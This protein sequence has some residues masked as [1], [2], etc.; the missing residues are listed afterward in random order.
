[1]I[2]E[3]CVGN[4]NE[5][6]MAEK[7]GAHQIE[8]CDRLDLDGTSPTL[9]TIKNVS[10]QLNIPVKVI[11]NP[12]PFNY[13]YTKN[14]IQKILYY[15]DQLNRL[16]LHGIVFGPLTKEGI[17][18]AAA[19]E[20]IAGHTDLPLTYHKA[21]DASKDILEST[22]ILANQNM[23]KFILSSGGKKTAIEGANQLLEMNSVVQNSQIKIIGAG[24]I[25]SHNLTQLHKKVLLE[26]YH[27]KKIVGNLSTN[28]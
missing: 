27:G 18:D 10:S 21:I 28:S 25:T 2:L 9:T 6:I 7:L 24:N 12:N 4:L 11:V 8:L 1:M 26:Y 13:V 3:A 22:R 16:S 23:V 15:L 20:T 19:I 5:A 14:D 17:P